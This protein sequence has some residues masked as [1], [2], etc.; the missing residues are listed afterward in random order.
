MFE[1]FLPEAIKYIV[2]G[3]GLKN[4]PSICRVS[5]TATSDLVRSLRE[6]IG[7]YLEQFLELILEI[8]NVNKIF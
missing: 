3:L 6:R 8:I 1:N 5:I 4:S 7:N 2:Y